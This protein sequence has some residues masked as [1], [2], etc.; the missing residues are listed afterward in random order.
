MDKPAKTLSVEEWFCGP[1]QSSAPP[2]EDIA[3][4]WDDRRSGPTEG[5]DEPSPRT[6]KGGALTKGEEHRMVRSL[7]VLVLLIQEDLSSGRDA[8]QRAGM[9]YYKAAGEK[10]LEA[11]GQL[12]HGE[13]GPWLKQ[14]FALTQETARTYMKLAETV[15]AENPSAL[16]ISSLGDLLRKTGSNRDAR[17]AQQKPGSDEPAQQIVNPV[18]TGTLGADLDERIL[19]D[20]REAERTLAVQLIDLGYKALARKLHP[21]KGGSPDAMQ[22]LNVVRDRLKQHV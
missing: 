22:R 17:R 20:E 21:D 16:G 14:N 15:G 1:D 19:Q 8:A 9:P 12:K 13:W 2:E 4:I 6:D 11:K 10:L 18:G 3:E 7:P 5:A